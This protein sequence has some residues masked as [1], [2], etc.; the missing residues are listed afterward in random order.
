MPTQRTTIH[1]AGQDYT[2][3]SE[4][5]GDHVREVGFIVDSKI[6]EI[7]AQSPHLDT[8]QAAVLA[9]IQ[10][11]SEHVKLKRSIGE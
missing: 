3:V 5:S 1:I 9:A 10:L 8:R 2:I 4:E 6:R 11:A 7:R